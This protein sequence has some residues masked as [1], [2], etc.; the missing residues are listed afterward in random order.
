M[1]AW[2][3]DDPHAARSWPSNVLLLYR[4]RIRAVWADAA[5]FN[6]A[7]LGFV[8]DILHARVLAFVDT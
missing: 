4:R 2:Y 5:Y 1:A 8:R 6:F 7:F 3:H